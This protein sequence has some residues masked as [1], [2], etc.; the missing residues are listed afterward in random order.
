MTKYLFFL[1]AWILLLAWLAGPCGAHHISISNTEIHWFYWGFLYILS[2]QVT[3]QLLDSTYLQ[4]FVSRIILNI[5]KG[6][7]FSSQMD[8]WMTFWIVIFLLRCANKQ[9]TVWSLL[10]LWDPWVLKLSHS[11]GRCLILMSQLMGFILVSWECCG[12]HW[13]IWSVW[14]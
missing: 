8:T 9:L 1:L 14:I 10:C 11:L 12:T 7:K 3:L 6:L 2:V 4:I 13:K 5:Q